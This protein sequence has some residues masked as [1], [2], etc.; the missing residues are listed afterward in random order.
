MITNV[1]DLIQFASTNKYIYEVF[2]SNK[3]YIFNRTSK[4]TYDFYNMFYDYSERIDGKMCNMLTIANNRINSKLS[5]M[6]KISIN[7]NEKNNNDILKKCQQEF[8]LHMNSK[9]STINCMSFYRI[10][11]CPTLILFKDIPNMEVWYYNISSKQKVYPHFYTHFFDILDF[12]LLTLKRHNNI[13]YEKVMLNAIDNSVYN[14]YHFKLFEIFEK[15]DKS[16]FKNS[17]NKLNIAH[18]HC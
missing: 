4:L 11:F 10:L 8:I 7:V 17:M 15:I 13:L 12:H 18:F 16:S 6:I 5:S 9:C 14:D 1:C 2:N 3:K